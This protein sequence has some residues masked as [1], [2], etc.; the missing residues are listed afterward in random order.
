[1][2]LPSRRGFISRGKSF[3]FPT[4]RHD[5]RGWNRVC[6][7]FAKCLPN[8]S[9]DRVRSSAHRQPRVG[10]QRLPCGRLIQPQQNKPDGTTLRKS[11][12][13]RPTFRTADPKARLPWFNPK[14]EV[15]APNDVPVFP[16]ALFHT[17]DFSSEAPK[18]SVHVSFRCR[19]HTVVRH[20]ERNTWST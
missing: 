12:V 19:R 5:S 8:R 15:P 9:E 18:D 2:E 6:R 11:R 4:R 1:M 7:Q 10:F 3:D 14:A 17:G 16:L 13:S 20:I